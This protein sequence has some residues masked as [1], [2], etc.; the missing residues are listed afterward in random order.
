MKIKFI[1]FYPAIPG[2]S[3]F[4]TTIGKKADS[5]S[6][7]LLL[8]YTNNNLWETEIEVNSS[9]ALT[10]KYSYFI[11][12]NETAA[13]IYDA[14]G[15]RSIKLNPKRFGFSV[16][17]DYFED[18]ANEKRLWESSIFSD[19][20]F[21]RSEAKSHR[22]HFP[23]TGRYIL[24]FRIKFT[25]IDKNYTLGISGNIPELGMWNEKEALRLNSY[26]YPEWR[27]ALNTKHIKQ[28]IEY[29]YVILN[30]ITGKITHWETGYNHI[31]DFNTTNEPC[32]CIVNDSKIHFNDYRFRGAGVSIPV[33]S[34]KT[35][36]SFGIGDF[37]DLKLLTDWAEKTRL[38]VIQILPINDT[39]A[40]YSFLDSY[41]Y[42]TI[43]VFALN[44]VYLNIFK[45]GKLKSKKS[46]MKYEQ[47]QAELNKKHDVDYTAVLKN[48][49]EYARQLFKE[50]ENTILKE[51]AFI[52]F[53]SNNKKWLQPYSAFC[54][55]RDKHGTVNFSYWKENAKYSKR[56][57]AALTNED[58]EAYREISFWH[59]I[60]Y[61]LNKQLKEA[62]H[63]A[64]RK[65]ISLKGDL[66]IGV[67]RYSTETWSSPKLFHFNMQT[68][69]PPDK[70][71]ISGQNWG[72]PTYN[73]DEMRKDNYRWWQTRLK[74]MAEYFDVY[75][76]DHILGF[77]RI[78]EIPVETTQGIM[79]HF[80]P[81]TPF[82]RDELQSAGIWIDYQRLCQPYI[83][84]HLLKTIFD[85]YANKV[86]K[87]YLTESELTIY[88]LKD[89]FNTQRKIKNHF[90][91]I[92]NS[93]NLSEEDR[94]IL[95]GLLRLAAEVILIPADDK[96]ETF[97]PAVS[98]HSTYSYS[99]LDNEQ[100]IALEKL[101][102]NYYHHRHE[103]LWRKEAMKKLPSLTNST[104]M[105]VCGEDLGMIPTS[106]PEV[107][108]E[109]SILSLEIQRMPKDENI[110]FADPKNTPYLS[111]CTTSTHDTSTIRGWWEED[112]AA[113]Q[114][115]YNHQLGHQGE[116]P[117]FAEPW[118]CQDIINRHLLSPSMW[119]IFPLQDLLAI[120][121]EIRS[122]NTQDEQINV[123]SD[124][125]HYWKY[126]MHI[127]IEDLID[128]NDF[129]RTI[130]LMVKNSKRW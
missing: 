102:I 118:L 25:P 72:F 117:Y 111:V 54:Y 76:I 77:F 127:F 82:T 17:K 115:Y 5:G 83:R 34:L 80:S 130:N 1:C 4:I 42:K 109:L 86:K 125:K 97:H 21:N 87:L 95:S 69:A 45:M 92:D 79:G 19:I 110:E 61:H 22:L 123:P 51:N 73:W 24:D 52:K 9:D 126:R 27:V 16:V 89:E 85:G 53:I 103:E 47:L 88:Q 36:N 7:P 116:M 128:E 48:K 35:K 43:S 100:K 10:F 8:T 37:T 105:L 81:A 2:R 68:G 28:P 12:D 23:P 30:S 122:D 38:K 44:P 119:A 121:G 84:E 66:P 113:S 99:E 64:R 91:S 112:R 26:N 13:T 6:N 59:F 18:D 56:K 75:R 106:V 41:P 90:K 65:G 15:V 14:K 114:R 46:R 93:K 55:L 104:K 74:N 29:K 49:I 20:L 31:I 120:S 70:F 33:F 101:Y 40:N 94:F 62:G 50:H 32:H 58:S 67:G 57:I 108:Q 39:T 96:I 63:Y 124:P 71:A 3:I 129:N 11:K 98:M 78:W 60:Q 107:M